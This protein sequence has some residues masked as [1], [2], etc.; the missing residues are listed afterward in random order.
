VAVYPRGPNGIVYGK[1]YT[2]RTGKLLDGWFCTVR[3][4]GELWTIERSALFDYE[5]LVFCL[6][7]LLVVTPTYDS[8]TQLAECCSPNPIE[9]LGQFQW[10]ET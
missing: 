3:R 8:A 1:R 9:R 7:P 5:V 10:L 6:V 4:Y 2:Q